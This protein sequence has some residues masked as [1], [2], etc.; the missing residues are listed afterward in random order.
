MGKWLTDQ[1]I[2]EFRT[3][4]ATLLQGVFADWVD[5]LRDGVAANIA[6]P[7]HNARNYQTEGGGR[8]FVDYCN[9]DRINQYR[10]FIFNSNAAAIGI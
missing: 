9:W 8:F 6:D 2:A 1:T 5:V 10:D 3:Q 7:A 4:G